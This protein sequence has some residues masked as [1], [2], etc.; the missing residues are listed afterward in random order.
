MFL[1]L[2]LADE[3]TKSLAMRGVELVTGEFVMGIYHER[4]EIQER[5]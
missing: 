3:T 2:F 4:E 1:F 5:V